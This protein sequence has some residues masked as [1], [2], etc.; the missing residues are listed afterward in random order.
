MEQAVRTPQGLGARIAEAREAAGLTQAALAEDL[1]IDRTSMVRLEA[2]ERKVSATE[3]ATIA[4]LL[5]LPIDWFVLDSPPAVVSRRRDTHRLHASTRALD[6]EV[7]RAARD[8]QFLLG[9]EILTWSTGEPF[10]VPQSHREAEQLAELIRA[11]R[12]LNDEP[13]LGLAEVA[14][15]LGVIAFSLDLGE[16]PDGA[17]VELNGD[18]GQR[19]GVAVIN[20]AE[21][22]GRR[23][24]S[25]AHEL[26]HFLVGDAYASDHPAGDVERYINSFVSYLLMP[27]NGVIRAWRDSGG[28]HARRAALL[29][30][31]RYHTSWSAACSQL[32]NVQLID[33]SSLGEL[34]RNEPTRGDYVALGETWTEELQPPSVPRHY[35]Q[36]VLSA[37]KSGSLT[38]QRTV[39]LLRSTLARSELPTPEQ[40][41]LDRLRT[42]FDPLT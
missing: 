11:D 32:V 6:V 35:A 17:C 33:H 9:R 25:L 27:R 28:T 3:L 41:G 10:A 16:G 42:V 13:L 4:Q 14:E 34:K 21:D 26:G 19:I 30:A 29:L 24:W 39:E 36:S 12:G 23:R 31:A 15:D 7:D 38:A 20:G 2:G 22:P 18:D 5:G 1:S 8:V 40:I 37:Y